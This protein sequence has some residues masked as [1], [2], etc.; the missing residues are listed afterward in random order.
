MKRGSEKK[1]QEVLKAARTAL[2]D[3]ATSLYKIAESASI[4]EH[5]QGDVIITGVGKSGFI[6]QKFAATLT[7]LGVRAFFIHPTEALH[8]DL[9]ALSRGDV[10]VSLSFSGESKEVVGLTKYAQ[11]NF[12]VPVIALCK[13]HS[14]SLGK[15]A[16][17]CVEVPVKSE[18]SPNGI[19]PMA[20]TTATLVVCDMIAASVTDSTFKNEHFAAYHPGGALGLRL[21]KVKE[22]MTKGAMVPKVKEKSTFFDAIEEINNKKLGV[23][24]VVGVGQKIVGVVTDGDIR[25]F[26]LKNKKINAALVDEVMTIHPKIVHE[27]DSLEAALS[28]M[29]NHKITSIF[30]IN[31]RTQLTG[32]I[33]VHN[34]LEQTL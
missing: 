16:D 1:A 26:V 5:R 13:S 14:S 28:T 18:G 21:K 11:K 3:L 24:A 19:A 8:G 32:I 34:I 29:E 31:A 12:K 27:N 6:G 4:I 22:Y 10:L 20:S 15:I 30:V 2:G 7:S 33:H 23:T 17:C 25:R 9:G